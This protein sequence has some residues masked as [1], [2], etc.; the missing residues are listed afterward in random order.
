MLFPSS[1]R[2]LTPVQP[3]LA[4]NPSR[5]NVRQ[6]SCAKIPI[7]NLLVLTKRCTE[8]TKER[9]EIKGTTKL[10]MARQHSKGGNHM[11][12]KVIDRGQWKA[13]ME[14]HILQWMDKSKLKGK[15]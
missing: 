2:I 11:N 15:R 6:N 13:L 10:K 9:K 3:V 12:K 7:Y 5:H 1:H 4:K 8:T 14:G